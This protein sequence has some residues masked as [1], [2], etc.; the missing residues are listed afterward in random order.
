MVVM[1][2][3]VSHIVSAVAVQ[4]T[5]PEGSLGDV[6][7]LEAIELQ[8]ANWYRNAAVKLTVTK[9]LGLC[10]HGWLGRLESPL[11]EGG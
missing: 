6:E 9:L 5:K 11:C 1:Q 7:F 8:E 2:Q 4:M 3:E 10:L